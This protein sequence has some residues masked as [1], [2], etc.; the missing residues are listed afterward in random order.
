MKVKRLSLCLHIVML[1]VAAIAVTACGNKIHTMQVEDGVV[2]MDGKP[3]IVASAEIDYA[4]LPREYWENRLNALSTMGLNTVTVKI[5]WMLHEPQE[6]IFDFEGMNDVKAFC[7]LAQEKGLFVWLHIGPYVGAEW[8]MGGLPWWLLNVDGIRLRSTQK[9]FMQRVERYFEALG[10]EFSGSL[11][12][13]GGNIALLQIEEAQGLAKTDKNYLGALLA[14]AK[15][16]GF[17]NIVTF[18]AGTKDT[19][20]QSTINEAYISMDIDTEISAEENFIGVVKYRFDNPQVCSSINSEYKAVWGGAVAARNWN[21]AFMRMFE[22]VKRSTSFSI[23]GAVAGNS[24]GATAGASMAD[25][26]YKPFTTAHNV[27]GIVKLWGGVDKDFGRFRRVLLAYVNE[28]NDTKNKLDTI[29]YLASFAE[30][31][32]KDA[33]PLFENL[34]APIESENIKTM[35]QCGIGHGAVLYSTQLP[36]MA[37]DAKLLLKGVHD[38]AQVFVDGALLATID[39]RN[40][41]DGEVV[42][43]ASATGAKLDI[44]VDATGR[45]GDVKGYKDYKG[46]TAGV[47][48]LCDNESAKEL[49]GW[50]IYPLPTDYAFATSKNYK[51]VAADRKP[52]YYRVTFKKERTGDF[53]LYMADWGKGEVWLNGK[54]LGRFWNCGP[55]SSLYVPDCWVKDG[56][57][58]LVIVDWIGPKTPSILGT[59]FAQM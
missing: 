29:P 13:N 52:G 11:I 18:T 35:E 38:Y 12:T 55:Q 34:P 9:A 5:P 7:R 37:A 59:D 10:K 48:L 20:I 3:Y 33:A 6:G 47:E 36:T 17:D 15:K 8:D 58:E 27:D 50:K 26:V 43:P 1:L 49:K 54:P 23:N 24:Y 46:I 25:G 44:L 56:A 21:K 2:K 19:Y 40:G 42:V 22:L 39:R 51:S 41:E 28:G 16:S 14:C 57:N 53:Y 30:V 31:E 4:R 32:V 45:V